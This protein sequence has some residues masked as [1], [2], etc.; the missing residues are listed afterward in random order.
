MAA[1]WGSGGVA[2]THSLTPGALTNNQC[3]MIHCCMQKPE[4]ILN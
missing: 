2:D 1:Y 4:A 3:M